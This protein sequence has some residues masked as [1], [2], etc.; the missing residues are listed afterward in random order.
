M[1]RKAPPSPAQRRPGYVVA[2]AVNAVMLWGAH[3]IL[4]WGWLPFLTSD[5]TRVLP[6][7]T[8]SLV[9]AIVLNVL[10]VGYDGVWLKAPA[11]IV[12]AVFGIVVSVRMWQVFPFDFTG[13]AFGWT[14]VARVLIVLSIAG[15]ATA[16]VVE[17]G[18]VARAALAGPDD[19][20]SGPAAYDE[21]RHDEPAP[22][23]V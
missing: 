4:G 8:A 6:V 3:R 19:R 7:L 9:T 1:V 2:I 20:A 21:R 11:D 17:L 15:S 16:I 13:Y 18:R 12:M 5:W 14:T 22:P 10:F 23:A